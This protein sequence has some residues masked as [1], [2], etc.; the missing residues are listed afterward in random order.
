[1]RAGEVVRLAFP[2]PST[3][4]IPTPPKLTDDRRRF[5]SGKE[6]VTAVAAAGYTALKQARLLAASTHV[7]LWNVDTYEKIQVSA[8][9]GLDAELRCLADF[10]FVRWSLHDTS[11]PVSYACAF[12][13]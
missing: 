2:P 5:S 12:R 10:V 4:S 3:L 13:W 8:A 9:P 1:M 7:V 11:I 6:P